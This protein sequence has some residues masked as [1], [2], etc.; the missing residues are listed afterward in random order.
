MNLSITY[1]F[2]YCRIFL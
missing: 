1:N 2:H